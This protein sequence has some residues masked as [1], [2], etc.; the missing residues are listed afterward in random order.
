MSQPAGALVSSPGGPIESV[1]HAYARVN[2]VLLL[3]GA[4]GIA[5]ISFLAFVTRA[6]NRL[7]AGVPFS[8]WDLA[9]TGIAETTAVVAVAALAVGL[10]IAALLP[11][12]RTLQRSAA[13]A[14]ALLLVSVLT[15]AGLTAHGLTTGA[16]PAVRVSFGAGFWVIVS[17]A[18]LALIDALQRLQASSLAK[19]ATAVAVSA[20]IG[21]LAAVGTFSDLSILREYAIRH[22]VFW[23]E[24]VRH[25]QLVFGAVAASLAI[26]VPFGLRALARPRFRRAL[27]AVLNFVQTIPSIA[28][29]GFLIA[30]LSWLATALPAL[31]ALGVHGI[32]VVPAWIALTGYALL[33][34]ARNTYAGFAGVDPAVVEA[35]RGLGFTRL[36]R[37]WR[38]E[39]PL[40]L[41]ALLAGLRMVLVQAIGLAVVAALIGAGGLGTFVFQGIGQYATDLILLGVLPTIALALA[42]E[43]LVELLQAGLRRR[44]AAT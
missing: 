38:I 35:A 10:L 14:A 29:F 18:I 19:L 6:P 36:Q 23:R 21:V 11:P 25:L 33:P 37:R 16:G 44:G 42:A 7:V 22:D 24:L 43:F 12:T 20:A 31:Q 39:L 15:A 40:A 2:R 8:L 32:G 27:F 28:L 5:A 26:G 34:I 9:G 30:P 3:L 13:L 1:A 41:P 4:T 17:C